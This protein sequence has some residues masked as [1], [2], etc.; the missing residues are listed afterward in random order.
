M[1]AVR[2]GKVKNMKRKAHTSLSSSTAAVSK[3]FKTLGQLT[4]RLFPREKSEKVRSRGTARERG[5]KAADDMLE[6]LEQLVRV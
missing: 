5:G 1:S 6:R 4:A 2:S 3:D